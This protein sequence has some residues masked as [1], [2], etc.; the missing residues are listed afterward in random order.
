M[1]LKATAGGNGVET[2]APERV[3]AIGFGSLGSGAEAA[4]AGFERA[5]AQVKEGVEKV[6]KVAEQLVSFSQ[7]NLEAVVKSGQIWATG[8]QDLSKQ[9]ATQAQGSLDEGL[10]VIRALAGV[11]SLKEAID[12][13]TS[14]TRTAFE[15][16]L[17]ESGRLTESSLKL[18]EQASAPLTARVSAAVEVFRA[19]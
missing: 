17:A 11:K 8:L 1:A 4:A 15:K 6:T 5:Q 19:S 16:A 12:L 2:S 9:V 18:A 14:F 10:S 7:G 13:Q 3:A